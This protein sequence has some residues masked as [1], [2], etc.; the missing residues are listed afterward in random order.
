MSEQAVTETVEDLDH[1]EEA[2]EESNT[3]GSFEAFFGLLAGYYAISGA[4]AFFIYLRWLG[5]GEALIQ[6][7]A[8]FEVAG[9]AILGVVS[10]FFSFVFIGVLL[11]NGERVSESFNL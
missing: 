3:V 1:E 4:V 2:E 9:Q 8:P 11:V 7:M 5:V 6:A 10:L